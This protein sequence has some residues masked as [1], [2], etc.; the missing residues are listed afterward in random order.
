MKTIRILFGFI[1]CANMVFASNNPSI[2]LSD[3]S[4]KNSISVTLKITNAKNIKDIKF[5]GIDNIPVVGRE[6]SFNSSSAN[7]SNN[8]FQS[9]L[10]PSKVES[11]N[12]SVTANLDGKNYTSNQILFKVTQ[13]QLDI[14]KSNQQKQQAIAK[15]QMQELQKQI[16]EQ[17]KAQQQFF[18]NIN[19]ILL[20]QQEEI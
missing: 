4:D 11:S 20:K 7:K 16:T 13:Q 5:N 15:K 8:V 1:F 9:K 10:L 17:M 14:I 3:S 6:I 2:M 18:N 19:K 12:I